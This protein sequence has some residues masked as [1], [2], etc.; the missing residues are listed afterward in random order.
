MMEGAV[1]A[2]IE[3]GVV[4]SLERRQSK[5]IGGSNLKRT[6]SITH[7]AVCVESME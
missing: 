4:E 6:V 7:A 2:V 5:E 1:L 3:A